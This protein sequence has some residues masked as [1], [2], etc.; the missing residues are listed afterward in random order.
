MRGILEDLSSIALNTALE[1]N[2]LET[3][4]QL[5]RT[6]D[7]HRHES[8]E[9]VWYSTGIACPVYN[10]VVRAHVAPEAVGTRIEQTMQHFTARHVPMQWFLGPTTRPV[11]LGRH[12]VAYGLQHAG[13]VPG[14]AIDL[15]ALNEPRATPADLSIQQ[16]RDAAAMEQWVEAFLKG[17]DIVGVT[18]Q[19]L[20]N[21]HT[22][23]GLGDNPRWRHYLGLLHGQPVATSWLSIGAGVAGIYGVA[24][25]PDARRQGLGTALTLAPLIDARAMGYRIGI[26]QSTAMGYNVY[27]RLGFQEY[28]QFSVYLWSRQPLNTL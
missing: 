19:E 21:L 7:G 14:M 11:D 13:E 28:C 23:L 6:A 17:Y 26:L 1:A 15:R 9:L 5:G 24:T 8:P 12:L 20:L 2:L 27:R 18:V 10:M 16:V 25:L 3:F 22:P 4:P